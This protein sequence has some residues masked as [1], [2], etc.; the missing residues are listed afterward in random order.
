MRILIID[1]QAMA[2]QGLR[3]LLL[4]LRPQ[5]ACRELGLAEEGAAEPAPDL[6]LLSLPARPAAGQDR[7]APLRHWRRRCPGAALV[8]LSALPDPELE[9]QALAAGADACFG[10]ALD[11]AASMRVLQQALSLGEASAARRPEFQHGR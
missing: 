8:V 4:A 7:L 3:A 10:A 2:R 6:L 11:P 1:D 9:R 5:A